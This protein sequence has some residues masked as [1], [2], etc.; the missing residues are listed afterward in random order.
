MTALAKA[1]HL[2]IRQLR[3]AAAIGDAGSLVGAAATLNVTQ[4]TISKALHELEA[5]VGVELFER[6]RR[7]V[8]PTLFGIALVRHAKLL[9]SQIRHAAEELADLKDGTGGRVVVGTLLA[10]SATLL[11][12]AIAR[13]RRER[14][15]C[16]RLAIPTWSW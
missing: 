9:M 14:P 7:G 6:T 1:E 8:V 12:G 4:P 10:A 11:P 13:L 16:S 5:I 15:R 2:T 3:I